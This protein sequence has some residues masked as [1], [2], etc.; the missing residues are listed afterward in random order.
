MAPTA[1]HPR[2]RVL[3][4]LPSSRRHKKRHRRIGRETNAATVQPLASLPSRASVRESRGKMCEFF[5]WAR[6]L[7]GSSPRTP[8]PRYLSSRLRCP[9]RQFPFLP[10]RPLHHPPP[11]PP[12]SLPP[13]P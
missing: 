13:P 3:R 9:A 6:P 12:P 1:S 4:Q 10:R 8:R 7:D 5:P 11:Q 2:R